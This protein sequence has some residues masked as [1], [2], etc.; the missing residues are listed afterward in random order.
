MGT[1]PFVVW[2]LA[3]GPLVMLEKMINRRWVHP[4]FKPS[5]GVRNAAAVVEYA[6][7]RFIGW[8]LWRTRL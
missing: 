8:L 3:Y 6:T 2:M 1:W 4:E 7:W 5:D